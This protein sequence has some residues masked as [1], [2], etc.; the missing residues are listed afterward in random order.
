MLCCSGC[1]SLQV[2]MLKVDLAQTGIAE[3]IGNLC[4]LY[5]TVIVAGAVTKLHLQIAHSA[6]DTA[7]AMRS[8]TFVCHFLLQRMAKHLRFTFSDKS[9]GASDQLICHTSRCLS[10]CKGDQTLREYACTYICITVVWLCY[11]H[12]GMGALLGSLCGHDRHA[13]CTLIQ[14][15]SSADC[16]NF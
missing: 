14:L 16:L 5:A 9:A 13:S 12:Y 7:M 1:H 4:H 3:T 10:R 11:S 15:Y 6:R 8:W 2:P